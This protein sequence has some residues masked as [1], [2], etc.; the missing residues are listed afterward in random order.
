MK[1][2]YRKMLRIKMKYIKSCIVYCAIFPTMTSIKT[3]W[4]AQEGKLL[5]VFLR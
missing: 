2:L 3:L 4:C 1:A 5:L